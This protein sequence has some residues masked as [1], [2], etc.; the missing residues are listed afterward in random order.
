MT[1]IKFVKLILNELTLYDHL[2]RWPE[3]LRH[4]GTQL[5]YLCRICLGNTEYMKSEVVG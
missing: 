1:K 2:E 4:S 5:L 3:W